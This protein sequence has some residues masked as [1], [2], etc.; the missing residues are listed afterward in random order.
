[1]DE[2]RKVLA[3][4]IALR[5]AVRHY[6]HPRGPHTSTSFNVDAIPPD[7][8]LTV[9]CA[10]RRDVRRSRL[11]AQDLDVLK[12]RGLN[13]TTWIGRTKCLHCAFCTFDGTN[14]RTKMAGFCVYQEYGLQTAD[15]R[16]PDSEAAVVGTDSA[17]YC[18]GN[19]I[20]RARARCPLALM[21]GSGGATRRGPRHRSGGL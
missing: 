7:F 16:R 8:F 17:E 15:S 3:Y 1:M 20:G 14:K 2:R 5:R 18:Q 4:A 6:V 21:A 9:F 19:R 10:T 12:S 13:N 11:G